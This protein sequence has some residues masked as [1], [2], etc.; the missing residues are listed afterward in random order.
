MFSF[1]TMLH[2]HLAYNHYPPI[3]NGENFAKLAIDMVKA[4]DGEKPVTDPMSGRHAPMAHMVIES[5]HLEGFL[6]DHNDDEE[7]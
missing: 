6:L 4:G 1:D 5:W 2:H 3:V 7:G